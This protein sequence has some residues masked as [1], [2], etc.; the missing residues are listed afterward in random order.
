MRLLHNCTALKPANVYSALPILLVGSTCAQMI[1][2]PVFSTSMGLSIPLPLSQSHKGTQTHQSCQTMCDQVGTLASPPRGEAII[3]LMCMHGWASCP[4]QSGRH[5]LTLPVW[6]SRTGRAGIIMRRRRRKEKRQKGSNLRVARATMP[7][8]AVVAA[9]VEGG[10]SP[11]R[12]TSSNLATTE[13]QRNLLAP[14]LRLDTFF[15]V[16]QDIICSYSHSQI[17]SANPTP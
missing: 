9:A 1:A 2:E 15:Y 10:T 6:H 12:Q 3:Q 8:V 7:P 4:F 14:Q 5:S 17:S 11:R 16:N 13:N